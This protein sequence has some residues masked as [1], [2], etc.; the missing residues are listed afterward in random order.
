MEVMFVRLSLCNLHCV[1]CDTPYTWN[2]EGTSFSHPQKFD[3]A[4]EV[5]QMSVDEIIEQL[6]RFNVKAVVVSGGEP[7]VQQRELT[8]LVSRLKAK[9]YWVE[10]ETNGTLVPTRELINLVDQ[11]N[12]SPKLSNSGDPYRL[13]IK[14]DALCAHAQSAKTNFKFVVASDDDITEIV[15]LVNEFKLK[16]V[17]LMPEGIT[18]EQLLDKEAKVKLLCKQYGFIFSQR[19]HIVQL[20]GGRLV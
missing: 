1:W 10:V 17:Y 9:G 7:L 4:K 2:W 3:M 13:R 6:E 16:D 12:C 14:A 11:F 5:I 18:K 8:V 19:I 15:A 20:G